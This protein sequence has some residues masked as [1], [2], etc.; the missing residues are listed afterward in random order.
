MALCVITNMIYSQG[1]VKVSNSYSNNFSSVFAFAGSKFLI[2]GDKGILLLSTDNGISWSNTSPELDTQEGFSGACFVSDDIG[3]AVGSNSR[4]FKTIDGGKTWVKETLPVA[5]N[6]ISVAFASE[7]IGNALGDIGFVL[8]TTDSGE[9][10]T[11]VSLPNYSNKSAFDIAVNKYNE[12]VVVGRW[13]STPTPSISYQTLY[14]TSDGGST[15][16]NA[17]NLQTT[18]YGVASNGR[19]SFFAVGE[20]GRI[21]R[22]IDGGFS[23]TQVSSPSS[24]YLTSI[25]FSDSLNGVIAGYG[26]TILKTTDG[27]LTWQF[28]YVPATGELTGIALMNKTGITVGVR[29][30]AFRSDD[31]GSNWKE[32][33]STSE[34]RDVYSFDGNTIFTLGYSGVV[35]RSSD[36]GNHWKRLFDFPGDG[37]CVRMLSQNI[38]LVGAEAGTI[39]RSTD[40]GDSWVK[41]NTGVS[42]NMWSMSF[43]DTNLGYVTSGGTLLRTIN[44]G[45]SWDKLNINDSGNLLDVSFA[46]SLY[47]LTVGN[48][49]LFLTTDGGATWAN[50]S[51]TPAYC[52]KMFDR[53]KMIVGQELGPIKISKD[54]GNSW[55]NSTIF[56]VASW[57]VFRISFADAQTGYAVGSA[58]SIYKSTNGGDSWNSDQSGTAQWL[59][60]VYACSNSDAVVVGDLGTILIS[61]G[62]VPVNQHTNTNPSQF[63]L[64]PN[65]PNPFNPN[66]IITF[67]IPKTTHINISI[68]DILGKCVGSIVNEVMN[69]GTYSAKW[70]ASHLAS[71]IYFCRMSSEG[72]VGT[73]KLI[74]AK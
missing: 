23:W 22:S 64:F 20:Y 25:S 6:L 15:W 49:G 72:Y 62:L 65:Y 48:N 40:T 33:F 30:I 35:L 63:N 13:T 61:K 69:P 43:N 74:L 42:A 70:N 57:Y 19:H 41:I 31:G 1:W 54:G 46:D 32:L 59:Y 52:C 17:S 36:K 37:K 73:K 55:Q 34:L 29:G 51:S 71:G 21:F 60:G 66:T 44:G 3:F 5:T 56:G 50:V 47:G 2:Y 4:V 16:I 18:L 11:P 68:Y 38:V 28:I 14:A 8:H 26:H 53:K 9:S 39:Y 24:E 10:W 7:L 27:G 67:S 45:L 12:G 58:G